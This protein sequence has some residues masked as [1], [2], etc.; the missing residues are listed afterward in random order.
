M[1]QNLLQISRNQESTVQYQIPWRPAQ[2]A[3]YWIHLSAAQDAGLEF[4]V[5]KDVSASVKE[6]IVRTTAHTSRTT[7]SNTQT[8]MGS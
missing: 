8:V 5:V 4:C 1:K 3:V 2:D 6:R 7:K